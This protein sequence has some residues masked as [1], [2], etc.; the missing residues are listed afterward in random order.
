MAVKIDCI[1]IMGEVIPFPN[2]PPRHEDFGR[3]DNLRGRLIGLA[4][5]FPMSALTDTQQEAYRLEYAHDFF[6]KDTDWLY[7]RLRE[8]L[9]RID[10]LLGEQS[11][12]EGLSVPVEVTYIIHALLSRSLDEQINLGS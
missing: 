2:K 6:K 10:E 5:A 8:L 3:Y 9:G 4:E 1:D 12:A 11:P 7:G